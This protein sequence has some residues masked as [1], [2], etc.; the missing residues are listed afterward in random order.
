MQNEPR[1]PPAKKTKVKVP[2]KG[3]GW[4]EVD[5]T[6]HP[7][8]TQDPDKVAAAMAAAQEKDRFER[9]GKCTEALNQFLKLYARDHGME[10]EDIISAVYLENCNNRFFYPKEKGGKEMFD[11]ITAEVWEWFKENVST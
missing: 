7:G 4:T 1:K 9:V 10:P 3:G 11:K 6:E 8:Q 2:T 5:A